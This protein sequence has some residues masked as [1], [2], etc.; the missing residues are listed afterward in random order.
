MDLDYREV[1]KVFWVAMDSRVGINSEH[2]VKK[3]STLNGTILVFV[4]RFT[5]N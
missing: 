4:D 1:K 5:N 3:V 2:I